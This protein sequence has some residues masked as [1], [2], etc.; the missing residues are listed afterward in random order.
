MVSIAA[1]ILFE[2][3]N[4]ACMPDGSRNHFLYTHGWESLWELN[5]GTEIAPDEALQS[6]PIHLSK[7]FVESRQKEALHLIRKLQL[8]LI[9]VSGPAMVVSEKKKNVWAKT[10]LSGYLPHYKRG[11][12]GTLLMQIVNVCHHFSFCFI[13]FFIMIMQIWDFE[14]LNISYG[15]SALSF[16]NTDFVYK[17]GTHRCTDILKW[18]SI[19]L[20]LFIS[21]GK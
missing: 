1:I 20:V 13:Q 3:F 8:L 4:A 7:Y 6:L 15:D 16:N 17:D 19:S 11:T 12:C 10:V 5:P 9:Q 18:T 14:T 2:C 21:E